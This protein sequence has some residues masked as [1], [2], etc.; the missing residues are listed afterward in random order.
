MHTL[1]VHANIG[2]SF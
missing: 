2:D 1:A